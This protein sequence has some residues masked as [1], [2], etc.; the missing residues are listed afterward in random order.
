[1]DV[2]DER[3]LRSS[4]KKKSTQKMNHKSSSAPETTVTEKGRRRVGVPEVK[5]LFGVTVLFFIAAAIAIKIFGTNTPVWYANAIAVVALLRQPVRT[6]PL[7]LLFILIADIIAIAMFGGDSPR[8]IAACDVLEIGLAAAFI[9]FSGG[10][11][12]PVFVGWQMFRVVAAAILVPMLSAMM[13]GAILQMTQGVPFADGWHSWYSASALGMLIAIPLLLSWLDPALRVQMRQ[14]LTKRKV[15]LLVVGALIAAW[16]AQHDGHKALL[17]VSYPAVFAMTAMSGLAGATAGLTAV[18]VASV[19]VTLHGHGPLVAIASSSEISERLEALQIFLATMLLSCMPLTVI[20]SRQRDLAMSLQRAVDARSDFLAAMSHEIRTPMTGVLG[21]VDLLQ[22]ESLTE[23]QRRYV[24]AMRTSGRHLLSVINDI[25]DFSR[26]E[27][28]KLELESEEFSIFE[29]VEGIQSVLHPLAVEKGIELNFSVD[30]QIP[31]LLRGDELRLRQVLLNLAGNAIKFTEKGRVD[32]RVHLV[33][34]EATDVRLR[35]EFAD[36]GVGMNAAQIE[37]LFNAFSQADRSIARKYGGTGLGLAISKRLVEAMGGTIGVTSTISEGSLFFFELRF[38]VGSS[39]SAKRQDRILQSAKPCRI[40]VAEDVEINREVLSAVLSKQGHQLVFARDGA[41][42][43][44]LA[45]LD[46]F[47]L[48]L[49]DVQMPVLDGVEATRRIRTFAGPRSHVPI[50]G[51]TANVMAKER[52]TY[53][54][55]GMDD[56]LMKPIDWEKL[57]VAIAKY[58]P[59]ITRGEVAGGRAEE[60]MATPVETEDMPP[61]QLL[62][63][64]ALDALRAIATPLELSMLIGRGFAQCESYVAEMQSSNAEELRRIAHKLRGASGMI[65]LS[66]IQFLASQ[67]EEGTAAVLPGTLADLQRTIQETRNEL[68]SR[69]LFRS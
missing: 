56:C 27:S 31:M 44:R 63:D 55:A 51:L 16:A 13:A 29:T 50:I 28:G 62:D 32:V 4:H 8:L 49:M 19:W 60:Q 9:H 12:A 59:E 68:L 34:A 17:F 26:I 39:E 11:H 52:A 46:D 24:D 20:L 3:Q 30:R 38:R 6:W 66:R 36:T 37:H 69:G 43:V 40:L 25:L 10:V 33:A 18:L 15:A 1:M 2:F 45:Q 23:R 48:I 47:D 14:R 64:G 61:H 5:D 65:G 42:A 21:M 41:E 22:G 67:I 35:F 53:L 58:S 54:R 7:F 57:S